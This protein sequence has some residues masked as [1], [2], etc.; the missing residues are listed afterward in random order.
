MLDGIRTGNLR[1]LNLGEGL[2]VPS[3][4]ILWALLI[5]MNYVMSFDDLLWPKMID[6]GDDSSDSSRDGV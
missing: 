5:R 2:V 3:F 6:D 4:W 1:T